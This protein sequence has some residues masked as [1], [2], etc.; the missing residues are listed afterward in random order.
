MSI[1]SAH[2]PFV[3][4]IAEGQWTLRGGELPL[5]VQVPVDE[6]GRPELWTEEDWSRFFVEEHAHLD[7]EVDAWRMQGE[8]A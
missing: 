8:E 4:N 2:C 7:T 5:E 3:M 1:S 6:D